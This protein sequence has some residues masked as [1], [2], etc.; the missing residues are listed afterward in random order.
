MI[1]ATCFDR[2]LLYLSI[3]AFTISMMLQYDTIK[4]LL[5]SWMYFMY[6][7]LL[8]SPYPGPIYYQVPIL[9]QSNLRWIKPNT[10]VR[11]RGMVQDMFGNELYVGAF[12][13]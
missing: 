6:Y 2:H 1:V 9:N 4:A 5:E 3:E 13:V 11:I 10:L 7:L 12:K 8:I